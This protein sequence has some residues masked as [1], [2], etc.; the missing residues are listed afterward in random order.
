MKLAQSNIDNFFGTVQPPVG[1]PGGSGDPFG[2]LGHVMAAG[3]N[4]ALTIA[5]VTALI[6]LLWGALN[7]VTSGGEKEHIEA[8]RSKLINALWGMLVFIIVLVFW[9]VITGCI[10]G[11]VDISSGISFNIPT[12]D[13]PGINVGGGCSGQAETPKRFRNAPVPTRQ[14]VREINEPPRTQPTLIFQRP[15]VTNPAV[16]TTTPGIEV[17]VAMPGAGGGASSPTP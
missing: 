10:L 3:I 11:I 4:I 1:V 7:W 8:A 16:M 2:A 5:G 9:T 17:T 13:S 15:Q 14:P 6:Y 12:F